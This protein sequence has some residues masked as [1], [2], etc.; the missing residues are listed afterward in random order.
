MRRNR[1]R[2]HLAPPRPPPAPTPIVNAP[3][4][5]PIP[6]RYVI[7]RRTQICSC[8][9]SEHAWTELFTE[10]TLRHSTTGATVTNLRRADNLRFNLPITSRAAPPTTTPVCHTCPSTDLSSALSQLPPPD[11]FGDQLAPLW[12]NSTRAAAKPTLDDLNLLD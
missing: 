8:C 2:I 6:D 3:A 11:F 4:F 12:V 7:L 9:G 1:K 5:D 10:T